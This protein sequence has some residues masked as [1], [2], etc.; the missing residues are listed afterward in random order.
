MTFSG[1]QTFKYAIYDFSPALLTFSL[2]HGV[3]ASGRQQ[4]EGV[5]GSAENYNRSDATQGGDE[6]GSLTYSGAGKKNEPHL[7]MYQQ[8]HG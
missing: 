8:V 6:T 2:R 5:S 7:S 4:G 3:E 1:L